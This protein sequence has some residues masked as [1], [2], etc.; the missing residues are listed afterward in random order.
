[1][2]VSIS[3]WSSWTCEFDYPFVMPV[4]TSKGVLESVVNCIPWRQKIS[5]RTIR[6]FLFS[7]CLHNA[8]L[9]ISMHLIFLAYK[10]VIFLVERYA[11]IA[12]RLL[13]WRF[14]AQHWRPLRNFNAILMQFRA[15]RVLQK[16]NTVSK[17]KG[18][19]VMQDSAYQSKTL[20]LL[21]STI[22]LLC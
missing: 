6:E 12:P 11:G 3:F 15:T 18:I 5:W 10:R 21:I 16:N 13:L 19:N 9:C 20:E 2:R 7:W 14:E 4:S 17:I 22:P 1:M 8:F